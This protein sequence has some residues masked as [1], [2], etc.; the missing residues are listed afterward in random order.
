MTRQQV[1]R[2]PARSRTN[3]RACGHA[4]MRACGH[5]GMPRGGT[6]LPARPRPGSTSR[7]RTRQLWDFVARPTAPLPS[8]KGVGGP[9]ASQK[10]AWS[11][12]SRIEGF[13]GPFR[14]MYVAGCDF[15]A[16]LPNE[17]T[18]VQSPAAGRA[19]PTNP[20]TTTQTGD[21]TI[22][23]DDARINAYPAHRIR[24]TCV[25]RGSVV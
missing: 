18:L 10:H 17:C 16:M 19:H 2:A 8:E 4:G 6:P 3:K 9:A 15:H 22:T 13:D 5:A 14:R 24:E 11:T 23:A 12:P 20:Q 7:V 21:A 25:E 1:N